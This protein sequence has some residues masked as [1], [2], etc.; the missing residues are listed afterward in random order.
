MSKNKNPS[1]FLDLSIEGSPAE[2][3]VIELFADIVPRTAENFRALC[4]G[5]K[6]IG[7]VTG[8][9][10]H[11]KGI[12]FHRIIKGFMAQGGDFS[13]Q[14]GTGGESIYGGKFADEN[15][16]L[17]HSGAGILSM[18]NGGPNT[19]GSQFFI[20][21]KR[22]PHLDGKHVVFGKVTKGMETIKKIELLGTS[23]G[24]PSG[25]VKIVDCGEVI[26]D[27]KNNVVEPV[28]GK[29][30]KT[31]K[32]DISSSDDSSDGRVKKRRGSSI[33]EKLRKRR[34]Y[35]PSDSDSESYSSESDSDS[36]SESESEADSDSSSSSAGGKRRKKRSTK[37]EVK[38]RKNKRKEKRRLP[39]KRSRRRSSGSSSETESGSSSSDDGKANRRVAKAKNRP[40]STSVRKSSPDLSRKEPESKVEIKDQNSKKTLEEQEL[41]K[42]GIVKEKE[43]LSN[44]PSGK[45]SQDSDDSSRSRSGGS[46][47]RR[48]G[49]PISKRVSKSP[50]Q[51]EKGSRPS[52]NT[53]RSRSPNGNGTPKRVRKGRGFTKEYSFA[54]RYRTPS[55]DRSPRRSHQF[56]YPQ[57]HHDRYPNYRRYSERSPPRRNRSPPRGR[58]PPRY[59]RRSRSQSPVERRADISEKLKSRLG[60][61]VASPSPSHKAKRA[62]S[63]SPGKHQPKKMVSV[64]SSRS[65]SRS[66]SR[67]I[68]PG[69]G[70]QRGLVSYG[71]IS[72]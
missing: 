61:R 38:Q 60:P 2:R 3:I 43:T 46:P 6:G 48:S 62:A 47:V 35:S 55:P 56:G 72:P 19:N 20:L 68:P 5:E 28:K 18:A 67:S 66:R 31:V 26:E 4:T 57:P 69:A 51:N 33:R 24:K 64:V 63:P 52:D 44:K 11:Y 22:Q 9:P 17:D 41:L 23:D 39:G 54:R 65:R 37:K 50:S 32:K 14:N 30:K 21:F 8:K 13:K 25:V 40:S 42:N 70:G 53:E 58:S 1:V 7:S 10:L 16:K 36:Y 71:D 34:K 15:F 59:R 49:S 29:K 45:Q 27:K 12:I